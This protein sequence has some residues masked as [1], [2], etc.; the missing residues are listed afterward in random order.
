MTVFKIRRVH[1]WVAV[2]AGCFLLVW[3]VSGIVMVLPG[4]VP[5][6]A[7]EAAARLLQLDGN[8][9]SPVEAVA[10]LTK[11]L[12]TSA[13]V[14]SVALVPIHNV[15]AYQITM[16]DGS[17]ALVDAKAKRVF[18]IT[19]D[20]AESIVRDNFPTRASVRRLQLIEHHDLSYPWGSLPAYRVVLSD[21]P[22]VRYHV[23]V[24]DG[25]VQASNR[26]ARIKTAIGSL[27]TFEPLK[28]I[29][30][31]DEARNGLLI[32]LSLVGVGTVVTGYYLA[33]LR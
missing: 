33:L 13:N 15:V 23:S 32:L 7:G 11:S 21:T 28:Y 9:I 26:W 22:H 1:K 17:S 31:K 5:A 20:L 19:P 27:H 2:T 4:F 12:N 6:S 10:L 24:K 25:A 14:I 29:V 8:E 18:N 30:Q 3:L 16:G